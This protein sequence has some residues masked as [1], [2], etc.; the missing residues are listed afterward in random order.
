MNKDIPTIRIEDATFINA[1][2]APYSLQLNRLNF[3]KIYKWL[4][5]RALPLSR[6][7]ADKI[8]RTTGLAR[9]NTE[10]EMLCITHG[11]SINDNFW[12]ADET[13]IGKIKYKDI[14]VFTNSLNESLY[15][16]ALKGDN[17]FTITERNISGEYTGQGTYPK[18]FVRT[19]DGLYLYKA[20]SDKE[21][22]KEIYASFIGKL[23]GLKTVDYSFRALSGVNCSVSKIATNIDMSWESAFTV[24]EKINEQYRII[25]Q[26]YAIQRFT[27]EYSNM[28]IF[29]AIILND[30]RH[31]KN[32]SFEFRDNT[33]QIDGLAASYDYNKAFE[34]DSKS[35]S[36]LIFD[37]QK[38]VNILKAGMISYKNYGTTLN[39][40]YLYNIIDEM[41]L[42]SEI[43]NKKALKNRI[44]YII[45]EKE[46]QRD[47]Y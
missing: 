13:E 19:Q 3:G 40:Q 7:N 9:D 35:M 16:V 31:M 25:P 44:L 23:L 27:K 11:V 12:I 33:S 36:Q 5:S 1:M 28:I 18:C 2:Y 8:Y 32:W 21:I 17:R 39:L 22:A 38:R 43:I 20:G 47:C 26:E 4:S 10:F 42:K 30:D 24:S 37:G 46:S 34:A 45:G 41:D 15:M 14:N 29:D 6:K